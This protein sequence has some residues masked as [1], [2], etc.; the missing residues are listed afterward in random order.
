[1]LSGTNA[2]QLFSACGPPTTGV[3]FTRMGDIPMAPSSVP[4]SA[5]QPG[6]TTV[7]HW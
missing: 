3:T 4:P 6:P 7:R 5:T 1:M 2:L